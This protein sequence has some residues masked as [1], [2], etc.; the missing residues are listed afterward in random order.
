MGMKLIR[1][2]KAENVP[3]LRKEQHPG[4]GSTESLKQAEPKDIYTKD[5][6]GKVK[7]IKIKKETY[8]Q[9]EKPTDESK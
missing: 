4:S 7:R 2:N 3:N 9:P 8:K 5:I 6:K 1:R